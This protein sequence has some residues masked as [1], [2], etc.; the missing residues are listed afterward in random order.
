[1]PLPARAINALKNGDIHLVA[2]LA[3]KTE[4]ELGQVKNLGEK[5]I[6]EIKTALAGLG[7]SLGLRIDPNILAALGRG[8]VR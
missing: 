7:L 5:S 1:M 6:D 4:D 2:D 8:A 3:Q